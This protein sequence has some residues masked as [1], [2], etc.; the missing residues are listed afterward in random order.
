MDKLKILL[1]LLGSILLF[2]Q[3]KKNEDEWV[4]CADCGLSSWVGTYEGYGDYYSDDDSTITVIDV[5]TTVFIEN[6]YESYLKITVSAQDE[7]MI[8]YFLSMSDTNYTIV[9]PGSNKSLDLTISRRGNE[10][11]LA[12]TAKNY[13]YIADTILYLDNSISFETFKIQD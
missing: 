13:H 12:G 10:Y 1:I 6:T 5:P 9:L 3:C 8:N 7:F 2:S 4:L 11:K